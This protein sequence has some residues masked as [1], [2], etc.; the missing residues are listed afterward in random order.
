MREFL[1]EYNLLI[2]FNMFG[3]PTDWCISFINK[4]L[5]VPIID[6]VLK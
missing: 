1:K 4:F 3:I 2:S 5:D 6:Q